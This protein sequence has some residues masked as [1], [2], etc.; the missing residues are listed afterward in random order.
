MARY[1]MEDATILDTE[2]ASSSWKERRTAGG[3]GCASGNK[4]DT[5]T[6][7]RSRKGRFYIEHCSCQDKRPWAEWV[8][9]RRAAAWL[10]LNDYDLPEDLQHLQD[11]LTE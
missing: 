2:N 10:L 1:R 4:W 9:T 5:E 8:D 11:E 6:L 7:H 3:I